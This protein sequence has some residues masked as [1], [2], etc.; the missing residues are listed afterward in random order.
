VAG[1]F[2]GGVRYR[3][4]K[5]S[6]LLHPTVPVHAP[7]TFDVIDRWKGASIGRCLYYAAPPD[8]RIY[9]E[10]PANAGEAELRRK[11]R[12]VVA[13]PGPGPMATPEQETNTSFPTTLD[14]R[15]P[16]PAAKQLQERPVGV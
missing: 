4:R 9:A 14:L 11:E 12:F 3:A 13:A 15:L 2:V 1:E 7:L 8:G 10:R 6:A 5:L 16:G